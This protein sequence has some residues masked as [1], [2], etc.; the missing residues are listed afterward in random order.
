MPMNCDTRKGAV[1]ESMRNLLFF[2]VRSVR[3]LG[4]GA[5]HHRKARCSGPPR[6]PAACLWKASIASITCGA[7]YASILT[8][9]RTTVLSRQ[10]R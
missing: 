5:C 6:L 3:R 1:S 4:L 7:K 10:K 2:S 9:E 8:S